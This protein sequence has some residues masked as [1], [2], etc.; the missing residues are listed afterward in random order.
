MIFL[1]AASGG[2]FAV[3]ARMRAKPGEAVA[4]AYP[5]GLQAETLLLVK[6]ARRC[7]VAEARKAGAAVGK[8]LEATG[9]EIAPLNSLA[10]ASR[11]MEQETT[12]FRVIA[13]NI[14][15]EPQ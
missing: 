5:S 13:K 14:K 7:T 3:R 6:L 1:L 12:R 15:L 10:E 11:L 4:L 8:A 2:I 9:S